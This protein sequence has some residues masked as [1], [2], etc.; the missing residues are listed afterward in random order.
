M[1]IQSPWP[2][3]GAQLDNTFKKEMF[4]HQGFKNDKFWKCFI[5]D[6][7]DFFGVK[8]LNIFIAQKPYGW[9]K[10]GDDWNFDDWPPEGMTEAIDKFNTTRENFAEYKTLIYVDFWTAEEIQRDHPESEI[11]DMMTKT[12]EVLHSLCDASP[13]FLEYAGQL[14]SAYEGS[15]FEAR[16]REFFGTPAFR[17]S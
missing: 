14:H 13:D 10:T 1:G 16:I 7:D 11:V 6:D 17:K 8:V 4:Y 9:T 2:A 5:P 12:D 15:Y 3:A